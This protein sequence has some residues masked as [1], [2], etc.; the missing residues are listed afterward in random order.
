MWEGIRRCL[1]GY[2]RQGCWRGYA[3]VKKDMQG[4]GVRG[5]AQMFKRMCHAGVWE[6]MRRCGS[7]APGRDARVPY[8]PSHMEN[9]TPVRPIK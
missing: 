4:R 2:A 1:K 5:D 7:H 6:G 3:D 9:T 8:P